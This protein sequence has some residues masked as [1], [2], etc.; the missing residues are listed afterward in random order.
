MNCCKD[1]SKNECTRADGKVFKLPRRFSRKKCIQGPVRGFTM[2]SSCAPFKFCKKSKKKQF[3]FNPNNPKKSFD[4]YINK[5]PSNTIPIKYTTVDDVKR[6][7]KK[8]EKLYKS[9]AYPHKRI[10][11]VGM[12]MKVRLEAMLKHKK[13][14]YPNA[15]KVKQRFELANKYYKFLGKRTDIKETRARKALTFKI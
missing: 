10:W 4:V 5:N 12:I 7:I 8:L 1:N 13:T 2:R 11:Q 15:K 6:T 9:G 14:K 3:L